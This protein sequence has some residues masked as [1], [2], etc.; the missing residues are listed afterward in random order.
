MYIY[1]KTTKYF[2]SP[3]GFEDLTLAEWIFY[4]IPESQNLYQNYL[5]TNQFFLF[6][7]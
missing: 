5:L 6:E 4:K 2:T 1:I 7:G 3:N